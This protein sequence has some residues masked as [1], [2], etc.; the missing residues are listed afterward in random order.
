MKT[1]SEADLNMS[2]HLLLAVDIMCGSVGGLEEGDSI[3]K[4]DCQEEW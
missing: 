1:L 2:D 3:A 4:I